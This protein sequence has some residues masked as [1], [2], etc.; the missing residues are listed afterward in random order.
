MASLV[1]RLVACLVAVVAVLQLVHL[2]LLN[3]LESRRLTEL[4]SLQQQ[5][6]QQ[7]QPGN[8]LPLGKDHPHL[9]SI[10]NR[11]ERLV[12]SG[13]DDAENVSGL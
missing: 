3:R 12:Q 5:Q 1:S 2:V 10:I 13:P 11:P 9:E 6:Q 7:Q 8:S 4:Q